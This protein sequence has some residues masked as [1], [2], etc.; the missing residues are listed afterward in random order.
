MT[1]ALDRPPDGD[2]H[3]AGAVGHAADRRQ[4]RRDPRGLFSASA[5]AGVVGQPKE[6]ITK[7]P[8]S[9][10][11]LLLRFAPQLRPCRAARD[12]VGVRSSGRWTPLRPAHRTRH[13]YW[14]SNVLAASLGFVTYSFRRPA[15]SLPAP[16]WVCSV[17][18]SQLAVAV[19]SAVLL[20]QGE[21]IVLHHQRAEPNLRWWSFWS[22]S[23]SSAF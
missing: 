14:S 2:G 5:K 21:P 4:W 18:P 7:G 8:S 19:P 20:N 6:P 13:G 23:R 3:R 10:V 16:D 22:S 9:R 1:R 12:Q 15:D 17:Y 11:A